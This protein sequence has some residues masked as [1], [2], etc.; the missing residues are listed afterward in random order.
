MILNISKYEQY[1]PK[2]NEWIRNDNYE[3]KI[4]LDEKI[5]D[6]DIFFNIDLKIRQDDTKTENIIIIKLGMGKHNNCRINS[7][8]NSRIPHF[9]IK[10][11]NREDKNN[12]SSTLYF[13]FENLTNE[14]LNNNVKGTIALMKE[15]VENF[16]KRK[17]LNESIIENIVFYDLINEDL[18][19]FKEDLIK[20]LFKCFQKNQIKIRTK[21]NINEIIKTKLC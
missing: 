14:S 16:V 19:S 5:E 13:Q 15:F 8:H 2:I 11:Y 21:E 20:E 4:I 6:D 12:F 1:F 7:V 17:G 9:E 3:F 10:Y 18:S